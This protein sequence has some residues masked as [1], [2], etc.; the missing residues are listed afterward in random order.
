M[1]TLDDRTDAE[2]ETW[3]VNHERAGA[4]DRPLY[5]ALLEERARRAKGS[6]SIETS[7]RHLTEAARSGRFTTYGELARASGME[8]KPARH[9]MN[10]PKGHLDRVS[11]I[12]FARRMPLLTALCVNQ[13]GVAD[14]SLS[15][16]ALKGFIN[17]ARRLGYAMTDPAQFLKT[18]QQDRFAWG[19]AQLV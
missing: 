5:H 13:E 2:I 14:G 17:C 1:T 16:E 6:L 10:G 19:R 3:I 18:Q 11:E 15:P 8:W 7:L 4:T 12:C 9:L